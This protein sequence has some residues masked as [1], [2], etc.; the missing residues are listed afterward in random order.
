MNFIDVILV[1]TAIIVLFFIVGALVHRYSKTKRKVESDHDNPHY[2]PL[3]NEGE[4]IT[5]EV[6]EPRE[7]GSN[8]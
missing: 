8:Q 3:P 2:E 1:A 4:T 5:E 7:R 6:N